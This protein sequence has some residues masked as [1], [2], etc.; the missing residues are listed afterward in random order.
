MKRMLAFFSA[1]LMAAQLAGCA[2]RPS[3]G[4]KGEFSR[5]LGV[6]LTDGHTVEEEDTHGGFLGDG[7]TT[8]IL[9]F[10]GENRTALEE[11]I[12]ETDG[13]KALPLTENLNQAVYEER[14]GDLFED[15]PQ[16]L[17]DGWYYF[18]DRHSEAEDP[19]DDSGLFGRGSFNFTLAIYDKGSGVL[20]CYEMDT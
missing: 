5:T 6:N 14:F 15:V 12:A 7:D 3:A 17:T 10:T 19:K 13:W 16:D 2:P 18:L 8:L 11:E 9:T 4:V 1:L 20:Y